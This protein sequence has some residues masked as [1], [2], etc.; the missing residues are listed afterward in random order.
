MKYQNVRIGSLAYALPDRVVASEELEQRIAPLYKRLGLH[1]GRLELMSGIQTRRFW[2]KGT[3]PSHAA[4][5]AGRKALQ[6]SG[7]DKADIGVLIHSS[8]CRDFM[9]PA[10]ASVVHAALEMPRNALAFDLSNAC[11]GF[12]NALGVAANM[13][14]SGEMKAALVVS[15]EDGG[16]LVEETLAWLSRGDEVSRRD[17]KAAFSSLTIGSGAVAAVL[18]RSED[19]AQPGPRLLGTTARSATEFNHLCSGDK[20]EG[21]S[22][23]LMETDSEALLQAGINLAEETF[24]QF[25]QEH[26]LTPTGIDKV[27]THQVGSAHRK[28]LFERLNLD[29]KKDYSTFPSLGNVGSVSMPITLALAAENNFIHTNDQVALLGIGSGLACQMLHVRW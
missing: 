3:R 9:E 20:S 21:S 16:P 12:A 28:L 15:G 10:T 8:V 11:L 29:L 4:A 22:G 19:P 14:E 1:T 6:Q 5:L 25:T 23:P 27:I 26:A 7:V 17:L 13:I 24:A 18:Q 2:P